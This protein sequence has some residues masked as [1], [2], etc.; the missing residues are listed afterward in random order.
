MAPGA[1]DTRSALPGKGRADDPNR[2]CLRRTGV[3][4]VDG[5]ESD[6]CRANFID[7]SPSGLDSAA[8]EPDFGEFPGVAHNAPPRRAQY[9]LASA[10]VACRL[11]PVPIT[12]PFPGASLVTCPVSTPHP[13]Y[14]P[15]RRGRHRKAP[16]RRWLPVGIGVAATAVVS[17]L[18]TAFVIITTLASKFS[19]KDSVYAVGARTYDV[20]PNRLLHRGLTER[21]AARPPRRSPQTDRVSSIPRRGA[22]TPRQPGPSAAPTGHSW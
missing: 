11:S 20:K 9:E 17:S 10:P 13:P 8:Q 6:C 1:R 4:Q 14:Q 12:P 3:A 19:A 5:Y 21:A 2:F 7:T 22:V 15:T 16:Q 18:L